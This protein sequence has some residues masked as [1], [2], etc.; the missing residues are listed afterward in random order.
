MRKSRLMNKNIF[1]LQE[2]TLELRLQLG[3]A[4]GKVHNLDLFRVALKT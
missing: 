2:N 3:N 4:D 1:F